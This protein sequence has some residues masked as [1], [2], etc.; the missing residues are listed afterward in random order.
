[1]NARLCQLKK[2]GLVDGCGCGCRGDWE[3]TDAG[4]T[5]LADA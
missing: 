5:R 2:K 3:L 4:R 1:M